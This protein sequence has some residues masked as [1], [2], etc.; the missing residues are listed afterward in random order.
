MVQCFAGIHRVF[1]RREQMLLAWPLLVYSPVQASFAKV[2]APQ[3]QPERISAVRKLFLM[4]VATIAVLVTPS[5]AE[6]QVLDGDVTAINNKDVI[7]MVAQ[8]LETATIIK[9]IQSSSCT[10]DTFPPVLKE[11]KRRGV[12]EAVLQ[13][14]V[15]A[16]YGPSTQRSSRAD[17]GEAPIYHYAEQLKQ[18]GYL[19]PTSMGR[20]LQSTRGRA[21]ASRS[22]QRQ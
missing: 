8:K 6:A 3:D 5:L 12:P 19:V 20:G 11:M 9:T 15:E 21:R 17:L 13:A 7:F 14:M 22:R 16:P 2:S 18:M 4:L 10:F 1:Q